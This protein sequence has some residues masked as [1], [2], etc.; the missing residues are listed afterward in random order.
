LNFLL[1]SEQ[2]PQIKEAIE[3]KLK[4]GE[5]SSE[6]RQDAYLSRSEESKVDKKKVITNITAYAIPN[7][8]GEEL[9]LK[10]PNIKFPKTDLSKY[11]I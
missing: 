4:I 3:S 10:F 11:K 2:W 8:N 1:Q 6:L 9:K 7:Y 5:K